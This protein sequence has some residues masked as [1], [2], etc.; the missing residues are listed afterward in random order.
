M[1]EKVKDRHQEVRKTGA[2]RNRGA[3]EKPTAKA[4]QEKKTAEKDKVRATCRQIMIQVKHRFGP[5]PT[6]PGHREVKQ[7][8]SISK[9]T[10][11]RL[12]NGWDP[13]LPA[14]TE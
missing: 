2:N 5:C 10:Q 14:T 1:W 9:E 12:L 4:C 13:P 7:A 6:A 3:S 8:T 11:D